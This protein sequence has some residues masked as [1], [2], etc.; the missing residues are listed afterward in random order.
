LY[1]DN[2]F[3]IKIVIVTSQKTEGRKKTSKTIVILYQKDA[4]AKF[5][6]NEKYV[7]NI[8]DK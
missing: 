8:I 7:P 6:V 3:V 4:Q 2:Y 1:F 5:L